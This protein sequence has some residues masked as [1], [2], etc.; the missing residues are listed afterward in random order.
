M[1]HSYNNGYKSNT[2]TNMTV[3]VLCGLF[4]LSLIYEVTSDGVS[5]F[6]A[7]LPPIQWANFAGDAVVNILQI[8][9]FS[10]V[11]GAAGGKYV[12]RRSGTRQFDNDRSL[13]YRGG[14]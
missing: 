3:I 11:A 5:T 10:I 4:F 13:P 1:R 6:L 9:I 8:V 7:W 14:K 12:H 2:K